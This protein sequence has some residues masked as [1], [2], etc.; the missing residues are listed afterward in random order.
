MEVFENAG[1]RLKSSP[2][3]VRGSRHRGGDGDNPGRDSTS[4]GDLVG[5]PQSPSKSS[6]RPIPHLTLSPP[7]ARL[8]RKPAPPRVWVA[9]ARPP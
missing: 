5:A 7:V 3:T 9:L 6:P 8:P 4:A 1:F 2:D